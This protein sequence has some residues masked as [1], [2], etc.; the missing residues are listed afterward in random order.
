[1]QRDFLYDTNHCS[2]PK[3]RSMKCS[4]RQWWMRIFCLLVKAKYPPWMC[5]YSNRLRSWQLN[6]SVRNRGVV[7]KLRLPSGK[8]AV[9]FVNRNGLKKEKQGRRDCK[10][11]PCSLEDKS[12]FERVAGAYL[13]AMPSE[14]SAREIAA[15][16]KGELFVGMS[17]GAVEY[18][19]L[20]SFRE[21]KEN[22][23]GRGG[24]QLIFGD[25][26]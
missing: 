22:D 19:R 20:A 4:E 1:M 2:R 11:P 18:S 21:G 5:R 24:K 13:D 6:T 12:F 7:L 16:R 17:K 3:P 25:S 9:T 23:W 14:F 8:E 26:V 10:I 15:I